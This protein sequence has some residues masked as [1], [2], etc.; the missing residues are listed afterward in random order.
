MPL[1]L[2]KKGKRKQ[3]LLN[4]QGKLEHRPLFSMALPAA[5]SAGKAAEAV[6]LFLTHTLLTLVLVKAAHSPG[7]PAA[8]AGG[9]GVWGTSV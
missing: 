6:S 8:A 2:A 5:Q 7:A 3:E 1:W 4:H 9:G